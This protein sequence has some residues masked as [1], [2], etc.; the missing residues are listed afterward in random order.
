MEQ[1]DVRTRHT[2]NFRKTTRTAKCAKLK[3]NGSKCR[4]YIR[5]RR[6][7]RKKCPEIKFFDRKRQRGEDEDSAAASKSSSP[8]CDIERL[9]HP[10]SSFP[11]FPSF[12]I[13]AHGERGRRRRRER[14]SLPFLFSSIRVFLE[15]RGEGRTDGRS[16]R[17]EEREE[18]RRYHGKTVR[19]KEVFSYPSL[20]LKRKRKKGKG[21]HT[22]SAVQ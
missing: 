21:Q 5:K 6:L 9:F 14:S 7:E 17:K 12:N 22:T 13:S 11:S 8:I 16:I 4:R 15:G 19:G 20:Y 18:V 1:T 10:S 3:A 2:H